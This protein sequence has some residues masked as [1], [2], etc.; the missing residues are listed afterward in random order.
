MGHA[1][2][3]SCVLRVIT[4]VGSCV[5]GSSHGWGHVF[6]GHYMGGVMYGVTHLTMGPPILGRVPCVQNSLQDLAYQNC[7]IAI[8]SDFHADRAKSPEIPQKAGVSGLEIATRNR[9]SLATF[10]RTDKLQCKVS[11]IASDFKA[12]SGSLNLFLRILP[13][14]LCNMQKK[15]EERARCAEKGLDCQILP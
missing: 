11:E 9:K 4:W 7:I 10:H 2:G 1:M 5:R 3:G 13:F 8:A 14:F 6:V 12:K 15:R